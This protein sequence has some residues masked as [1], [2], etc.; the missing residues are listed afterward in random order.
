MSFTVSLAAFLQ[1]YW[2]QSYYELKT[3]N[4]NRFF[5]WPRSS[6]SET[7]K[8]R[9]MQKIIY[10]VII[11]V[12]SSWKREDKRPGVADSKKRLK[13]YK[14]KTITPQ[15]IKKKKYIYMYKYMCVCILSWYFLCA[16][17]RKFFF[18]FPSQEFFLNS[19]PV[20]I[21]YV[22]EPGNRKS[23]QVKNRV[24][25]FLLYSVILR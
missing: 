17:L 25:F 7:N 18:Y 2:I 10:C 24:F 22:P 4:T 9:T 16:F 6:I 19:N 3:V 15:R 20:S 12:C 5:H 8:F 1:H 13:N 23:G 14:T 21:S 11:Y